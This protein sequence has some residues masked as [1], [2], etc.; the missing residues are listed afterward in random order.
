MEFFLCNKREIAV[1]PTMHPNSAVS[2]E[3]LGK[4]DTLP[5]GF[6]KNVSSTEGVKSW[7]FANFNIIISHMFH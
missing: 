2:K 7:F 6:S 5:C 1:K 4:L 3:F